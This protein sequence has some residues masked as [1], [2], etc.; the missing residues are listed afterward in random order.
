MRSYLHSYQSVL[1]QNLKPKS[2]LEDLHQ[3]ESDSIE[4]SDGLLDQQNPFTHFE[5]LLQQPHPIF[6]QP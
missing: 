6:P 4:P 2:P 3:R 5:P 1:N